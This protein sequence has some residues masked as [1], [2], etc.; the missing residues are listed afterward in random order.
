MLQKAGFVDHE[1]CIPYLAKSQGS[2]N[3]KTNAE[4]CK[5]SALAISITSSKMKWNKGKLEVERNGKLLKEA[6]HLEEVRKPLLMVLECK[7]K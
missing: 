6:K 3:N 4:L 1:N 5:V 2:K 7:K